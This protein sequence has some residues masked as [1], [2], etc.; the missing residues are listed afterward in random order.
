M[1]QSDFST[2]RSVILSILIVL[3][4]LALA[5]TVAAAEPQAACPGTFCNGTAPGPQ[6]QNGT[7]NVSWGHGTMMQQIRPGMG[8]R[9]TV[10]GTRGSA[11]GMQG[12]GILHA[13]CMFIGV[14]LAGLLL[15]VWLIVG[16]LLSILLWRKLKAEKTP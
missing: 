14:L 3:L 9:G 16:I 6:F 1:K 2:K 10:D 7:A 15:V 5:G 11:G 4:T 8:M 12:A 13:V